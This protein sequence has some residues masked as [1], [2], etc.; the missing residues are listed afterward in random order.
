MGDIS[1]HRGLLQN[2]HVDYKGFFDC[3]QAF[4]EALTRRKAG[5]VRETVKCFLATDGSAVKRYA[6]KNYPLNAATLNITLQHIRYNKALT[7]KTTPEKIED[8]FGVVIDHFLLSECEQALC[9]IRSYGTELIML[10]RKLHSGTF[11]TK[12]SRAYFLLYPGAHLEKQL[13]RYF[14][15]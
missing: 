8:M 7:E 3:A 2:N 15:I 11:K 12:E 4:G 5:S 9:T 14:L 6:L 1:L 10:V 13:P